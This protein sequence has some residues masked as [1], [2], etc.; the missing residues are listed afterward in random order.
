MTELLAGKT[1]EEASALYEEFSAAL[2]NQGE[3]P[4]L[5]EGFGELVAL[6]EVRKYPSRIKCAT[7]AWQALLEGD[8]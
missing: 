4:S 5:G 8:F 1:T 6:S 2:K 7:L 3:E